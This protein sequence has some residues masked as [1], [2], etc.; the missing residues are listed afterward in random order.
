[1][2]ICILPPD[3]RPA[4]LG[5]LSSGQERVARDQAK[6]LSQFGYDVDY[7]TPET[8]SDLSPEVKSHKIMRNVRPRSAFSSSRPNPQ[9]APKKAWCQEH[10]NKYDLFLCHVDSTVLLKELVKLGAGPK[11]ISFIHAPFAGVHHVRVFC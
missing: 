5:R 4:E 8:Q 1:V 10:F 6:L 2:R 3:Q 9:I 7:W 11:I